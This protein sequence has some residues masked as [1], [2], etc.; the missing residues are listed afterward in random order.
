MLICLFLYNNSLLSQNPEWK[1]YTNGDKV[2]DILDN[3]QFLWIGTWGGLVK[4][5]KNTEQ[6]TFYNRANSGIPD[7]HILSLAI[8]SSNNVWLGTKYYGVGKF[9]INSENCIVYHMNNSNLPFDQWNT[10]IEVDSTGNVWI[11]SLRWISKFDGKNWVT[12]ET[13][14]PLAP[15]TSINDIYSDTEG[16]TWIGAS[17]GLGKFEDDNIIE[18]YDGFDKEIHVIQE[19]TENLIWVGTHY[20]GLFK[21]DGIDW[22][23]YDTTNSG[24]PSNNIYDMKFD[25]DENLWI[26]TGNGL[27]KFDGTNWIVF[28][29]NNS[30]L[31]E[32]AILSLEIDKDGIIWIGF[33][34]YGLMKYDGVNWKKYN[35]SNSKLPI[36]QIL[37][38][39]ID[40]TQNIWFATPKGLVEFKSGE[41][42]LFDTLNSGLKND[43]L[44]S[45]LLLTKGSLWIGARGSN[46]LT[47]YDGIN[48]SIFDSTNSILKEEMIESI[49]EDGDGN[50]WLATWRGVVKYNGNDWIRYDNTNTPLKSN[51]ISDI[52][53]DSEDNLWIGSVTYPYNEGWEGCLAKFTGSEWTIF[54]KDNSELPE[55]SVDCLSIDSEEN[56]WI[57]TTKAGLV[58]YDNNNWSLYNTDNSGIISNGI[59]DI[60]CHKDTILI[61]TVDGLSIFIEENKWLNF[62]IS[63]SNISDNYIWAVNKDT[64]GNIWIGTSQ[65]GISIYHEGGIITDI[66]SFNTEPLN[67]LFTLN[68]NYPNPFNPTTT[69]GY[70]ISEQEFITL[71]IYDILGREVALLINEEKPAGT[72]KVEFNANNLPNGKVNLSS[73]VYFYRLRAGGFTDT[74]KFVLLR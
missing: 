3:D 48:W 69:I 50:I 8:D 59:R 4:L 27:V 42:E 74:K 56:L 49:K 66:N 24:I 40:N 61:G 31:P 68:Q 54:Q 36:N 47:K 73:G 17:W 45:L 52:L 5:N 51:I 58:K 41:W 63:N 15:F 57:G 60:Y 71:K 29:T 26:A 44:L 70:S 11:G 30:D 12:H 53:F 32:D 67:Q 39:E 35:L 20:N 25:N 7:N 38:I 18:K 65:G 37:D 6:T 22:A 64:Y 34:N 23:V 16:N 19:D 21:Y 43:Y 33:F 46:S 1:N 14:N 28:N 13:G 72:Y 10:E 2:F 55:N 62:N 9:N